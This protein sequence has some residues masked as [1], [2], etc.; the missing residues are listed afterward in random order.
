LLAAFG[1]NHLVW[2]NVFATILDISFLKWLSTFQYRNETR[3]PGTH[4]YKWKEELLFLFR[5][6]PYEMSTDLEDNHAIGVR[7]QKS[8]LRLLVKSLRLYMSSEDGS[9][10]RY[11]GNDA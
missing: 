1:I 7:L 4:R 11:F 5:E 9:F 3:S 6:I 10:D 2:Q 8:L